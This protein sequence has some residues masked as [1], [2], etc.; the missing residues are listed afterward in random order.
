MDKKLFFNTELP[1]LTPIKIIEHEVTEQRFIDIFT[2][3]HEQDGSIA[4]EKEKFYFQKILVDNPVIAE[5]TPLSLFS[6]FLDVATKGLTLDN[7]SKALCYITSR[8]VKKKIDNKDFWEKRALLDIS[9]YGEL[10]LRERANQVKYAD[11][12][13]I[14]YIDELKD[15]RQENTP[16]GVR[17]FHTI[18]YPRPASSGIAF[19]YV[20]IVR[21]DGSVTFG[22]LDIEGIERLKNFSASN[23]GKWQKTDNGKYVNIPGEANKLYSDSGFL[24]AKC[25]KHAFQSFPKLKLNNFSAITDAPE[26]PKELGIPQEIYD[27]IIKEPSTQIETKQDPQPAEAQT[28]GVIIKDKKLNEMF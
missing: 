4:Y 11:N 22:T 9:G 19:I 23:N 2:S 21:P 10:V 17:I 8:N 28:E 14:V 18:K 24:K 6:V 1:T 16:E 13:E 12:P 26:S 25:L 20:R 3:I 7:S 5:C 27:E 15:C